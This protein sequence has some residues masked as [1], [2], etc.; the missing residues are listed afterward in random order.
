MNKWVNAFAVMMMAIWLAACSDDGDGS[1]PGQASASSSSA[2]SSSSSNSSSSSSGLAG[3]D[4]EWFP[5]GIATSLPQIHITTAGEAPINSKEIYVQGTFE[6]Q[7]A[8][9]GPVMASGDLEIRGRGNSSWNWPK[10]PF[11]I[12]LAESTELLGMPASRHWV[13]LANYAD[14]TLIRNDIAFTLSRNMGFEYTVRDRHVELTINNQYRGIYQLVEQIR[15]AKNRVN[16]PDLEADDTELPTI[17]GGYLM[18][19]D[20]RLS[21]EWC[22]NPEVWSFSPFCMGT[23]N[24]ERE[25][26]LCIDSNHGMS[27]FCLKEPEDLLSDERAAQREYIRDYV[28]DAEAALFGEDFADPEVGYAAYI[29]VDSAINYYLL[30]ELI[31]N[32]DSGSASFFLHKKRDGKMFFGP[33]WDLDLALGNSGQTEIIDPRG[34]HLRNTPWFARLFED[35]AFV[36]KVKARWDELKAQGVFE[37]VF[38]YAE[39]RAGWLSV[40]QV[41]NFDLWSRVWTE[42]SWFTRLVLGS[43]EAEVQEMLQWQLERYEWIDGVLAGT[44]SPEFTPRLERCTPEPPDW[45]SPFEGEQEE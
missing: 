15:L 4:P 31:K 19:V 28:L 10:R 35:P 30:N 43:Y 22:L 45:T 32:V 6:V 42:C 3:P 24:T 34:W 16:V 33:I 13:L 39:R 26:T 9:G 20:F 14:K 37:Q 12:K 5:Q 23:V 38:R 36:A 21:A 41:D 17:S 2:S 1:S 29:D 7:D 44:L 8:E 27:P 25:Q 40:K 18:E 11:R